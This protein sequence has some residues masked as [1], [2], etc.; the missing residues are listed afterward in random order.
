MILSII[1]PIFNEEKTVEEILRRIT[2]VKLPN[3]LK[4]EII[5]VDDG[6]N[7][8]SK[9]KIQ[10]SK[11]NKTVKFRSHKSNL[12]KGVAVRTGLNHATGD[13]IIIQDGDLEYDPSYYPTLLAP[14]LENLTDIVYGTRFAS[15]PLKLWGQDKTILPLHLVANKILTTLTNLLYNA[16]LT[17][18]ETCYK[19]FK[20][21]CL[22]GIRL[23]SNG[24]N[25][26]P[27]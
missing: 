10:N 2:R 12:G 27:E 20:K 1:V 15:Y 4:K 22:K 24:F 26:E 16:K 13:I 18:M 23:K 21:D 8:N 7:D 9:F 3:P 14:I 11:L 17:D 19:V 6:S 25:F 5:V